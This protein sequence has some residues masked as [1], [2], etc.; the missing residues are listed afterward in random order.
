MNL[1]GK[2]GTVIKTITF[3]TDKGTKHLLLRTTILPQ[4]TAATNMAPGTRENNQ[5]MAQADRQAVFRGDCATCHANSNGKLGKELYTSVCGVCHEAEH[6]A[7]MVPDL[8]VA[9][10]D[11][12]ED[13]WRN[14]IAN[15]RMGSL[16]PAFAKASGGILDD[17]QISSLVSYLATN[18]PA[19]P[20]PFVPANPLAPSGL[21]VQPGH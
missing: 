16:M 5:R 9:R 8:H 21:N 7:S 3:S 10:I 20:M 18:M 1:A 12:N 19:K 13:Y 6:R 14:W 17:A 4:P 15:G 2:S 11:R